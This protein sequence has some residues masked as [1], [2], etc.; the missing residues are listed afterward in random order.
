MAIDVRAMICDAIM[1]PGE[2]GIRRREEGGESWVAT[3][4]ACR[5]P[6]VYFPCRREST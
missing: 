3:P 5:K 6:S 2:E 1:G 4:L